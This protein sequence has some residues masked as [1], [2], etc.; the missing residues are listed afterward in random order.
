MRMRLLPAGGECYLKSSGL[1]LVG[2]D[3]SLSTGG[4]I[5]GLNFA[6]HVPLASQRPYPIMVYSVANYRLHLSHFW[7]NI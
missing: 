2:D 5:R 1:I 3:S 7:T 6:G 4:A